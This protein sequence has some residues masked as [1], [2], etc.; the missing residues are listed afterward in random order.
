MKI[1]GKIVSIIILIS[2]V[3]ILFTVSVQATTIISNTV[4]RENKTYDNLI[5]DGAK[6]KF[7]GGYKISVKNKLVIKGDGE[8]TYTNNFGNTEEAIIKVGGNFYINGNINFAGRNGNNGD[9]GGIHQDGKT[10]KNGKDGK[11][12][13]LIGEQNIYI[14][15]LV[16]TNGGDGG[17]GGDGG[18]DN[19]SSIGKPGNGGKGGDG[20]NAGTIF[21]SVKK[22]FEIKGKISSSGGK[23]G[24]GGDGGNA[25]LVG[26][27][28]NGG[29]AG[30]GG[31][32]RK[33]EIIA[34]EF[35][36]EGKDIFNLFGGIIKALRGGKGNRGKGENLG[37]KA[38]T[39]GSSADILIKIGSGE[40]NGIINPF[41]R[42]NWQKD[43]D[44][45]D[46]TVNLRLKNEKD[47]ITNEA[48]P[49]LEWDEPNDN[50]N[51]EQTFPYREVP[52]SGIREYEINLSGSTEE[53]YTSD[54]NKVE[55][56][57]NN[58]LLLADGTLD[59]GKYN[60][61]VRAIDNNDYKGEWSNSFTFI[62]DRTPPSQFNILTSN[63][64]DVGRNEA[65]LKWSQAIDN[66]TAVA[67]Y[68]LKINTASE[69]YQKNFSSN[70][71]SEV[72]ENLEPNQK[73]EY[74]VSSFDI[75]GNQSSWETDTIVTKAA[76]ASIN[77][78]IT[79]GDYNK[80]YFSKIDIE[81]LDKEASQYRVYRRKENGDG[82]SWHAVSD[83]FDISEDNNLDYIDKD[84]L[85]AHGE[86]Q[87]RVDTKNSKGLTTG[88]KPSETVKIANNPPKF[89]GYIAPENGYITND[90]KMKML[91][92]PFYEG[93]KDDITYTFK[94]DYQ[95]SDGSWTNYFSELVEKTY[96]QNNSI[97]QISLTAS[98]A[99]EGNYRW[100]VK[101]DDGY[102]DKPVIPP[103][104]FF[105]TDYT[106]PKTPSFKLEEYTNTRNV[107]IENI[108]TGNDT[109]NLEVWEGSNRL[110]TVDPIN[111]KDITLSFGEEKKTVR[112]VAVDD[113]GNKSQ[114]SST[115]IYDT[116][117]P[118]TPA[119]LRCTGQKEG[120]N[121]SWDETF[122]NGV[123]GAV[124]G[125]DFYELTYQRNNQEAVTIKAE[126]RMY[127]LNNLDNNEQIKV[128]LKAV[129]KAG[130]KSTVIEKTGYSLPEKGVI[131]DSSFDPNTYK[132]TLNLKSTNAYEYMIR[133]FNVDG[134]TLDSEWYSMTETM[135]ADIVKPHG[136]YE[137]RVITRNINLETEAGS[138]DDIYSFDVPNQR[139][140]VPEVNIDS[141][142]FVNHLPLIIETDGSV[143][144]DNDS[145]AYYFTL[146]DSI[147]NKI[148]NQE[149]SN[150]SDGLS[151]KI[152]ADYIKNGETY[153]W[154]VAV[155]DGYMANQLDD[156]EYIYSKQV[157][158][159]VDLTVP[160]VKITDSN[161]KFLSD[162]AINVE[163]RDEISG[164]KEIEYYWNEDREN[165]K[166]IN[167]ENGIFQK[168]LSIDAIHGNN[169]LHV[170]TKDNAGNMKNTTKN[171]LVDKTPPIINNLQ[172][173]GRLIDG[174]Y[175]TTNSNSLYA[176][177]QLEEDYT[178]ISYYRYTV[179]DAEE[180]NY[181]ESLDDERFTKINVNSLQKNYS[182]VANVSLEE[183]KKYFVVVE[184]VNS[185]QRSTGFAISNS[186]KIDSKP[187]Q[188]NSINLSGVKEDRDYIYSSSLT[189]MKAEPSVTDSGS[190]V[191]YLE[192]TLIKDKDKVSSAKW[193]S[194]INLLNNIVNP[195]DGD[196]Y[197]LALKAVDKLG[198]ATI[199]YSNPIIYDETPPEIE[200]IIAGN[201]FKIDSDKEIY[202]VSPGFAIPVSIKLKDQVEL[203]NLS[204]VIGSSPGSNN[205]TQDIHPD[206][207]GWLDLGRLEMEQQFIIEENLPDG[208]YYVTLRAKNKIGLIKKESSNPIKVDSFLPPVPEIKD[209]GVYT[210]F[211]SELHFSWN[212]TK[213]NET[214]HYEY[215]LI[216]EDGVIIRDW[217]KVSSDKVGTK[218]SKVIE[219]L[220]LEN[221]TT[222]YIKLRALHVDDKYSEVGWSDGIT[223]DTTPPEELYVDDGS[224]ITGDLYLQW[225]AKEV[226]STITNYEVKVGTEPGSDDI[227]GKW[228][229]LDRSGQARLQDL[230]LKTGEIYYTTLR[231]TNGSGLIKEVSSNGFRVDS[232]PP[233]KPLVLDGGKY[234]NKRQISFNWKWSKIDNESGI[235]EYQVALLTSREVSENTNWQKMDVNT[236]IE[237]VDELVDGETYFLAVKAINKAGLISIGYSDGILIDTSRPNPPEISDEGDYKTLGQSDTTKL[238]ANFMSSDDESGID[239]Y[240]YSVGTLEYTDSILKDQYVSEENILT[241]ELL[242]KPGNVYFF[243]V[244]AIN[245]AGLVSMEDMSDG[246]KVVNQ[247]PEI[248]N[249]DDYGDFTTFNNQII[250]S[251][252]CNST[253]VPIDHYKVALSNSATPTN[254]EWMVVNEKQAIIT[255]DDVG[256][257]SFADGEKYYIYIKGIDK[258]GIETPTSALGKTD[259]IMVDSSPPS[260][261]V[262]LH[263]D[264]YTTNDL[265]LRWRTQEPDSGIKAYRY[266]VG[267]SRGSTD[268]TG[269]WKVVNTDEK[270]FT[271]V[272]NVNLNHN[273]RYFVTVQAL[274]R[275]G[276]WS[277][278]GSGQGV[279]ADLTPP[280]TPE[281]KCGSNYITNSKEIENVNW[282]SKDE[283]TEISAYRYQV[284][285]K[286]TDLQ[287]SKINTIETDKTNLTIDI[288][289]LE[290]KE[291][292]KYYL[293]FQTR[294][295]L[296][297][298][299]NTGFSQQLIVD[300]IPPK[301][302]FE[303]QGEEIVTNSG[304]ID[305]PW[306]IS[307]KAT[308][309]SRLALPDN[310][311]IPEIGFNE[312]IQEKGEYLY[313]FDQEKEGSYYFK[314]YAVDP[315]GNKGE[316]LQQ[317]VRL[318]AKPRVNLGVNRSVYKGRDLTLSAE[319]NDP[320]G[321]VIK[322]SW[323]FG[324]NSSR[325]NLV[326]PIHNYLETGVYDVTL[327]CTDNDGGIGTDQIQVEVTNTK[328]GSLVLDEIWSG[329]MKLNDTVIIPESINLTIL[330][331]TNII[332]PENKTLIVNG[333][334]MVE[335]IDGQP[336]V[337]TV[338][339]IMDRWKGIK[340]NPSA[341]IFIIN[342][343][344]IEWAE[345]GITLVNNNGRLDNLYIAGNNVGIHLIN[346]SPMIINSKFIN[347]N[348]YGIKEDG[349]VNPN[350][351]NNIFSD[352][353]VGDYYDSKLTILS[354]E[355]LEIMNLEGVNYVD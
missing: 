240:R 27:D 73:V 222:Y 269:E 77:S 253:F 165:S 287:W 200:E 335:G 248:Y 106:P 228:I 112:L 300:T 25:G 337:F 128:S 2:I 96:E 81:F 15:G 309:Y 238:A 237:Y 101:A 348:L 57:N 38:D 41:K 157:K 268:I 100:Y 34:K 214:K 59:E 280:T 50:P 139:P 72:I 346:S 316:L 243:T 4:I 148:I 150:T 92:K 326:K 127:S 341:N 301:I 143:D 70:V 236:Q 298:W 181:L 62:I 91:I 343:A 242:L 254:L 267:S 295:R 163:M 191:N 305:I 241:N 336:V 51:P 14:D 156:P 209:D 258:A 264:S 251:W 180:K 288:N 47:N 328:A 117:K 28:G 250:V 109:F 190:G 120:L 10:G 159:T 312:K 261:P 162:L 3:S 88:G 1:K 320:D 276:L 154:Q 304:K 173:N 171:Y 63:K 322:Y 252:E 54:T 118:D 133:R 179:V 189:E 21:I 265:T 66:L 325:S 119:N 234:T 334:L 177:W 291:T 39:A 111:E 122:D 129:D 327:T 210:A 247:Y 56:E 147:G 330:P 232:S 302:N 160:E 108:I 318:N 105:E 195:I 351:L 19:F 142:R 53:T 86:Y 311:T 67:G 208:T 192:Y 5:I 170:I 233:P 342:S 350:L 219:N 140:T 12:I 26:E 355:E 286:K 262:I 249:V 43:I 48:I 110:E 293:A 260:K 161:S 58:F 18:K 196:T 32:A 94:I 186:V 198:Q 87:Y 187:P 303:N 315:A 345:R 9:D 329:E 42:R 166:V 13:R 136:N 275:T 76:K 126:D 65:F 102:S 69:T 282:Q 132:V 193:V 244:K 146:E 123:E 339:S 6:L 29:K 259:G 199:V 125:I 229:E 263:P 22:Y 230:E 164:I 52:F 116:S 152:P 84:S 137:Y 257:E 20:G 324:D 216:S 134:K 64:D 55:L 273:H 197:Y 49:V 8:I 40:N 278:M 24:D 183:N 307:E 115:I 141:Y 202:E 284:I 104:R 44:A 174:V 46:K 74:E 332:F 175:Y 121:L 353:G 79:G 130:N 255:P 85:I 231:A 33:T 352:N 256:L 90:N 308:V 338:S 245:K 279:I 310:T 204:Y 201:P 203:K 35:N 289:N 207:D 285:K 227:T 71:Y 107:T 98:L 172:I 182:Q 176:K 340:V 45:P 167:F 314:L 113:A 220:S 306:S 347:N 281:V 235:K 211:N 93:D 83:W 270:N 317:K 290:L 205:I 99:E 321:E 138:E 31:N 274:N 344:T 277:E 95:N 135:F 225:G 89:E 215:Q 23:G 151:Y 97:N 226:E 213:D 349:D 292:N 153:N 78:V 124:S 30:S 169:K 149:I 11:R 266:A 299:S 218:Y 354:F 114:A 294:N 16:T 296:G 7:D 217:Q 246:I 158:T 194:D 144:K 131:I 178:P 221:G 272:L 206:T 145:L 103:F 224:Y 223:I 319:V 61:E 323:D 80:G 297:I 75:A 333:N 212:F 271:K 82:T 17:D 239:H 168:N 283:E 60:A 188:I 184:G 36:N 37:D 331:S 185:V 68:K 313:S 155:Y